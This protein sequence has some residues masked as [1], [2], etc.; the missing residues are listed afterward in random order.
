MIGT[1]AAGTALLKVFWPN[2]IHAT[3]QVLLGVVLT[4]VGWP[5]LLFMFLY[6]I[7]Y[8]REPLLIIG[9]T[10]V[11]LGSLV[12]VYLGDD[13]WQ[14]AQLAWIGVCSVSALVL[15]FLY[16]KRM[17]LFLGVLA[18]G[19]VLALSPMAMANGFSD[20]SLLPQICH[21]TSALCMVMQNR[22]IHNADNL[23]AM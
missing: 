17:A 8:M 21:Y 20:T 6:R 10:T 19:L 2:A 16:R 9:I 7:K 1:C 14:R 3:Y 5:L 13:L 18:A 22:L 4:S 23:H 12:L 11:T 15:Q